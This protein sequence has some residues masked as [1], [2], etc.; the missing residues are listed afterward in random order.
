M[1]TMVQAVSKTTACGF[2]YTDLKTICVRCLQIKSD[3]LRMIDSL[4]RKLPVNSAIY[5]TCKH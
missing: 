3:P 5:F 2:T 4:R 1:A